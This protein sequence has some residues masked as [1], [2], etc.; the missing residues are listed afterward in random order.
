MRTK[1]FTFLI[2]FFLLSLN[3]LAQQITS[4]KLTVSHNG[5]SSRVIYLAS[6]DYPTIDLSQ[7]STSSLILQKVEI[8]TSGTISN[9]KIMGTLYN[10]QSNPDFWL[11]I[12]ITSQ[13][14]EKWSYTSGAEGELVEQNA[15]SKPKIFEFY[16]AA[17][18]GNNNDVLYNNGGQNYK[19][20]FTQGEYAEEKAV[21][22]Y[23]D[24]T[25]EI[26]FLYNS[27]DE[28]GGSLLKC[29][30]TGDSELTDDSDEMPVQLSSLIIK[31]F[32]VYFVTNLDVEIDNVVM[33]YSVYESGQ[34]PNYSIMFGNLLASNL[35]YN[36]ETQT[37]SYHISYGVDD[38][39]I[40]L[41]QSL[42]PGNDYVLQFL[43]QVTTKDNKT[44]ILG[45][46]TNKLLFNFEY[47][48]APSMLGMTMS[49]TEGEQL[50]SD[51]DVKNGSLVTE[52]NC[53][54]L[55]LNDF[56]ITTSG[57]VEKVR[58]LYRISLSGEDEGEVTF[59]SVID[60][61]TN[62][63]NVW[64]KT[65]DINLLEN[66]ESNQSYRFYCYAVFY[67][68]GY[69]YD[70]DYYLQVDIKTGDPN[71]GIGNIKLTSV[72]GP[73]YNLSGFP[74]GKDYKGIVISKKRKT[75]FNR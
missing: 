21:K 1:I 45:N 41:T 57:N 2:A 39:S 69:W 26:D 40:D 9:V 8:E 22:F 4:V 72:D 59:P 33:F 10:A 18:D 15:D 43:F 75:L 73:Y 29:K 55:I 74:V 58:L 56:K 35:E 71:S 42:I 34:S 44:F 14:N 62:T 25:A 24:E 5:G 3:A 53:T 49:F 66:L 7:V 47:V 23:K 36:Q 67:A 37:S 19:I 16:I 61:L 12:P 64:S 46:K 70:D 63:D 60:I 30:F 50:I 20:Y 28:I 13:G 31:N 65:C 68:N 17:K 11:N 51:Y 54:Q 52:D 32:N 48:E 38:A 27:K 6:D